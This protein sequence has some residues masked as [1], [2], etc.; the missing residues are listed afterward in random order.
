MALALCKAPSSLAPAL[1]KAPSPRHAQGDTTLTHDTRGSVCLLNQR[2][3]PQRHDVPKETLLSF[4]SRSSERLYSTSS[5][6]TRAARPVRHRRRALRVPFGMQDQATHD[7]TTDSALSA[8]CSASTARPSNSYSQ[9][10]YPA[11]I[12]TSPIATKLPR[13]ASL[14][15]RS[16][17]S[18]AQLSTTRTS[19]ARDPTANRS[20][21][22]A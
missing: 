15:T 13:T 21:S 1:C 11:D 22:S 14:A 17:L 3:L 10:S 9:R 4:S 16:L 19:R 2:Q 6:T 18:K 5:P 7:C 12:A 20:P 8:F